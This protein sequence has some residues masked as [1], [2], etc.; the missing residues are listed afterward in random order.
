MLV[1]AVLASPNSS[2]G[3]LSVS[4]SL[5]R[6]LPNAIQDPHTCLQFRRRD[7]IEQLMAKFERRVADL[8]N[9]ALGP[10]GQMNGL[11]ATI[12]RRVLAR[13]PAIVFQSMQ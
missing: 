8:F 9:N 7:I 5:F 2:Y 11:A 3:V 13:Y 12:V 1:V 4:I 6:S 10:R